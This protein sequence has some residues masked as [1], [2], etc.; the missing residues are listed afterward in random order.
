MP[1]GTD[2]A[3]ARPDGA[4]RLLPVEPEIRPEPTSEERRAI[5]AAV[6]DEEPQGPPG[7]RSR[8]RETALEEGVSA[9]VAHDLGSAVTDGLELG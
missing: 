8:W 6:A 9:D 7:Y 4:S 5:L 2:P 3:N 1:S